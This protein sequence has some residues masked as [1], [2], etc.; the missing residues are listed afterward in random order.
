MAVGH[1]TGIGP[2]EDILIDPAVT[3]VLAQ[4]TG[5][6]VRQGERVDQR[7][8]AEHPTVLT[9]VVRR[10][11]GSDRQS[12][13][14]V[15][16]GFAGFA[17]LPP[18]S[19]DPLLVLRRPIPVDTAV[20]TTAAA[21]LLPDQ[22]VKVA[23]AVLRARTGIVIAGPRPSQTTAAVSALIETLPRSMEVV[24]V[25]DQP[26]IAPARDALR[27]REWPVGLAAAIDDAVTVLDLRRLPS[28]DEL[29]PPVTGA[30]CAHTPEAACARL[31][32][33]GGTAHREEAAILLADL[34]PLLLWYGGMHR[35]EGV[36]E[37][38]PTPDLAGAPCRLQL[39][40]G[41]DPVSGTLVPTGALPRH[42]AL[43]GAWRGGDRR[44]GAG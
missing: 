33:A 37:L 23:V 5:V 18:V 29:A 27:F 4:G 41:L 22:I 19:P 9:D 36:Y 20:R 7:A 15:L 43:A 42:P 12:G 39:L 32:A 16:H 2:L 28:L 14:V 25:E 6:E 26:R 34:M 21:G 17:A 11:L 38:L 10:L 3:F 31:A 8:L 35:V 24:L 40:I 44:Y 30:V 1:A 13:P